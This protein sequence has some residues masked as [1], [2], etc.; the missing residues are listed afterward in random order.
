MLKNRLIFK[1]VSH[2]L[3]Y[4]INHVMC[5][6]LNQAVFLHDQKVETKV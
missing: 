6:G 5:F 1:N 3:P 4:V 2:D